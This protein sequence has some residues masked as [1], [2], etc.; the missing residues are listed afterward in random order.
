MKKKG[1]RFGVICNNIKVEEW[2]IIS[3]KKMLELEFV[4]AGLLI[5]LDDIQSKQQVKTLSLRSI[6]TRKLSSLT[7]LFNGIPIL[8]CESVKTGNGEHPFTEESLQKIEGIGLDFLLNISSSNLGGEIVNLPRY[9]VWTFQHSSEFHQYFWEIYNEEPVTFAGLFQQSQQNKSIPLKEGCFA[10]IKDSFKKNRVHITSTISEWPALVCRDILNNN[11]DYMF[12]SSISELCSNPRQPTQIQIWKFIV[13]LFK[14]KCQTM[15]SKLFS[16]EFWNIGIIPKPIHEFLNDSEANIKWLVE[17]KDL[18]YADPFAYQDEGGLRILMEELDY[19]VVKGYISAASI[20]DDMVTFD[21]SV[22]K[23]PYHMSYPFILEHKNH[24][25][26]IPETSEAMEAS[27]YRINK[28]GQEW[29]KVKTLLVDF[30]AVDSTIIKYGEYWWLFCT[31]SFSTIQSHNNELHIFYS[32]DLFGDWKP[33]KLN[34][35]KID[36]RSSRPAGTPFIQEE[37]LYRPAQ[38]CSKTYGGR[39]VFNK[40]KTLTIS[41]FE[42]EPICFVEPKSGSLY[43]D[44]VHT[45]STAGGVTILDGKRFDYSLLHFFR[46][47]YKYKPLNIKH[48]KFRKNSLTQN[49]PIESLYEEKMKQVK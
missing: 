11:N 8:E 47:L 39:I 5:I 4:E 29:E 20:K 43:P 36:I 37:V 22:L 23:F 27:I 33:H 3:I 16:Y 38:D 17:K 9:G 7:D 6:F 28:K 21:R 48:D 34:P 42:E 35:V 30:P 24:I 18:Y 46:K 12:H 31:K 26:C 40:I 13:K 25:Y 15:Y 41:Q 1:L 45:I 2:Q 14:N 44:G 32:T 49:R 19:R 10:T